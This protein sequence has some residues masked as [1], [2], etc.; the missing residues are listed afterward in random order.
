MIIY[1][2]SK[3]IIKKPI[4][5]YGK[6]NNDYGLGFYCTKDIELAKEWSVDNYNDGYANKYDLDESKLKILNLNDGNYNILHW[7][8]LLLKNRE[9]S[10]RHGIQRGGKEYLLENFSIDTS[11]YDLIIGYR[12]DDSYFSFASDFLSNEI[13]IN[14]LNEAM[15][16]GH[17]GEQVVLKSKKAFKQI[18]Y[19]KHE[20]ALSDIYFPKKIKRDKQARNTYVKLNDNINNL[21]LMDII[22]NK[23]TENDERLYL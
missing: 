18:K 21:Y 13:S 2:G 8:T 20:K 6:T 5:G 14:K 9:F 15:H 1:H 23:V 19:I 22:R 10:L 7:L 4:Y 11:K 17:L 3:D 12:A 16:L